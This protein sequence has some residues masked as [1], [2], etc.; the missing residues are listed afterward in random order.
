MPSGLFRFVIK[1]FFCCVNF[2]FAYNN[3][4]LKYN[5]MH[6]SQQTTTTQNAVLEPVNPITWRR[7]A[8]SCWKCHDLHLVTF[9][10][11]NRSNLYYQHKNTC[12][13]FILQVRIS[14]QWTFFQV[15][16]RARQGRLRAKFMREIRLDTVFIGTWPFPH[17]VRHSQT[18]FLNIVIFLFP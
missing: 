9:S 12:V 13:A 1:Q 15:H 11:D 4:W 17:S 6:Q 14:K 18:T 8:V 5:I 10:W 7:L 16:E 3:F 2:V